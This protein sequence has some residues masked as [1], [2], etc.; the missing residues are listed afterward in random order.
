M[1]QPSEFPQN[2]DGSVYHLH[3][4]PE[5]LAKTVVLV[6]DPGRVASFSKHFERIDHKQMNREICTRTGVYKG[7]PCSVL[8]T[9][10]G[11]DNLDIVVNELDAL[12]NIDLKTREI[13][14]EKTSLNLVRI[15]TCGSLHE[16][17]EVDKFIASAYGFGIDG[18][19]NFYKPEQDVCDRKMEEAFMNHAD[20]LKTLPRPYFV[21][22]SDALLNR[23]AK[24][25]MYRGITATAQGFYGP[26]GRVLR[27][28]LTFPQMH[29]VL[30]S[31]EYNGLKITNL[32]METSALYG[33]GQSLGH[34]TLT[35]CLVVANRVSKKFSEDYKQIMEDSIENLLDRI[36]EIA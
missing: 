27:L 6:G 21:K 11:T 24:D 22:A 18:L 4:H 33:L 36:L 13:K 2:P 30:K 32:E 34:Q 16:N 20:W 7:K 26:Q 19:M 29:D 35:A 3:L 8:S 17:I 12:V 5:Q 10:M 1:I 23:V 14:S 25:D 28:P 15:G 9:G 31:F